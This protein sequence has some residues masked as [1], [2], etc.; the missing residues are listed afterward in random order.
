MADELKQL[1]QLIK[2]SADKRYAKK[3]EV[4]QGGGIVVNPR[5]I[6]IQDGITEAR[7]DELIQAKIASISNSQKEN[8]IVYQWNKTIPT[9]RGI[10]TKTNEINLAFNP[11]IIVYANEKNWL[12][13]VNTNGGNTKV[14]DTNNNFTEI[15]TIPSIAWHVTVTPDA[16]RVL[17]SSSSDLKKINIYDLQ[18]DNNY[19]LS[20]TINISETINEIAIDGI[21]KTIVVTTSS[22]KSFIYELNEQGSW[23]KINTYNGY[24]NGCEISKDGNL[25]LLQDRNS[26]S[27][28]Q[29]TKKDG[30]WSD[31]KKVILAPVTDSNFGATKLDLSL[32]KQVL[33][34]GD[35]T[36]NGVADNAGRVYVYYNGVYENSLDP[37]GDGSLKHFWKFSEDAN[38]SVG[39]VN[40]TPTNIT[41]ENSMAKFT[42]TNSNSKIVLDSIVHYDNM[43]ISF[44]II[45]DDFII[46]NSDTMNSMILGMEDYHSDKSYI[47]FINNNN[48]F[49]ISG[50]QEDNPFVYI[51]NTRFTTKEL[52]KIV[53]TI[54]DTLETKLYIDGVY[55]WSKTLA[56]VFNFKVFG[57]IFSPSNYSFD[58]KLSNVR[59]F[60][61]VLI[62]TEVNNLYKGGWYLENTINPP[63]NNTNQKFGVGVASNFDNSKVWVSAI[64][65]QKIYEYRVG[66][67]IATL[68][69][70]SLDP[71]NDGS[72]I[73]L[74]KF[75]GNVNNSIVD[76]PNG[77]IEGNILYVPN[78]GINIIDSSKVNIE[79]T[80]ARSMAFYFQRT[81][82]QDDSRFMSATGVDFMTTGS[83]H[84]IYYA[85]DSIEAVYIDGVLDNS[86]AEYNGYYNAK[87]TGISS[88]DTK[89][90][91]IVIV[92]KTSANDMGIVH[93]GGNFRNRGSKIDNL[94]IFDRALTQEEII[95]LYNAEASA[96]IATIEASPFTGSIA[97]NQAISNIGKISVVANNTTVTSV[98][99]DNQVFK[100]NFD[101]DI[102]GNITNKKVF[103]YEVDPTTYSANVT[104]SDGT[105]TSAPVLVT[106]NIT[107][108]EET[109]APEAP[110][111]MTVSFDEWDGSDSY[112]YTKYELPYTQNTK[113]PE[114]NTFTIHDADFNETFGIKEATY[115]SADELYIKDYT[116]LDYETK[117]QYTSL[118]TISN[119]AG[120]VDTTITV[121]ILNVTE[122]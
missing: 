15:E 72:L 27:I 86:V 58:G 23:N 43:S 36:N 30:I 85:S 62:P 6:S 104:F 95:Q 33:Y 73:G 122:V 74:F 97:E 7:I 29:A 116:K 11:N 77:V 68:D 118:V 93:V 114:R 55:I 75:D 67:T 25:L 88:S 101:I 90:Q 111:T 22:N 5:A 119:S 84:A 10:Y 113:Y 9:T 102:D 79:T 8:L 13:V 82:N 37:F 99:I 19:A 91:H 56:D 78:E 87:N 48:N 35:Y 41:F 106:V 76:K 60:D 49:A 44:D 71:F 69:A 46:N 89:Y 120:S 98:N 3:D 21:G 51:E 2:N 70:N 117:P 121:N 4:S 81:D 103:D 50:K 14:Y 96:P 47:R 17:G 34:I 115:G 26:K 66:D 38:D 54:S 65:N 109:T 83:N 80:N 107:D 53:V 108:V 1:A 20:N 24:Y 92:L 12:F 57:E 52:H 45:Q 32:D 110:S 112:V 100:D 18:T 64:E 94:Q 28:Y 40:G 39:G 59:V 16:K 42:G 61:K 31:L 63:T 105:I